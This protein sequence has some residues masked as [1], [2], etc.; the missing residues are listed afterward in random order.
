MLVV[1]VVVVVLVLGVHGCQGP[2]PA[3][4]LAGDG[5]GDH[6][7]LLAAGGQGLVAGVQAAVAGIGPFRDRCGGQGPA[8][9][10]GLGGPV[11]GGVVPG[12]LDQQAPGVGVAGLRD[13]ALG[14]AGAR[15]VLG[16]D[17]AEADRR[18]WSP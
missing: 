18:W 15:G 13:G 11:G 6:G 4:A 17:Q 3:G 10:Y 7:V 8:R 12:G 14:P 9:P 2:Q 5:G 1:L 16:G